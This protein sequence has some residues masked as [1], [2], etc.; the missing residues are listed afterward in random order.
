MQSQTTQEQDREISKPEDLII[1]RWIRKNYEIKLPQWAFW[2]MTPAEAVDYLKDFN[3]SKF[4]RVTE[5]DIKQAARR[6]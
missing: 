5:Q 1:R 2:K 6:E 4:S 3:R